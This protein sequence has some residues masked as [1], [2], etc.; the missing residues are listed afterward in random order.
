M[1]THAHI[2]VTIT[3]CIHSLFCFC[4]CFMFPLFS[5]FCCCCLK[6]ANSFALSKCLLQKFVWLLGLIR[7]LSVLPSMISASIN[8]HYFSLFFVNSLFN[9]FISIFFSLLLFIFHISAGIQFWFL[10]PFSFLLFMFGLALLLFR[11]NWVA[12]F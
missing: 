10:S 11:C 5:V 4:F 2:L 8:V 3:Y 1:H 7:E 12:F 6:N 9:Q